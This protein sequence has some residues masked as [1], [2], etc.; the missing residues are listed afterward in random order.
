[1]RACVPRVCICVCDSAGAVSACVRACVRVCVCQCVYV[2][3]LI[4]MLA[5]QPA[6][7]GL[8]CCYFS[9]D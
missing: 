6:C 8:C 1:M 2:S 4:L 3:V 5:P 9:N 7:S